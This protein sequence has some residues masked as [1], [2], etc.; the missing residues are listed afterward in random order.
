VAG[1]TPECF[2]RMITVDGVGI[3]VAGH[4]LVG[5]RMGGLR[6]RESTQRNQTSYPPSCMH[7]RLSTPR[8]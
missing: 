5:R 8:I 4:T 1:G 7:D 3:G 6:Q 2:D